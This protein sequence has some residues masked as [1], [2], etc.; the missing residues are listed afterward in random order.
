MS[1]LSLV[2]KISGETL[3]VDLTECLTQEE[4]IHPVLKHQALVYAAWV[5]NET[6][7]T[8]TA[9]GTVAYWEAQ[10]KS[11]TCTTHWQTFTDDE[12][13]RRDAET[14]AICKRCVHYAQVVGGDLYV[15]GLK[16][17]RVSGGFLDRFSLTSHEKVESQD[18]PEVDYPNLEAGNRTK[19]FD[20]HEDQLRSLHV[21]PSLGRSLVR[22]IPIPCKERRLARRYQM[23]GANEK[24]VVTGSYYGNTGRNSKAH[25]HIFNAVSEEV[26]WSFKEDYEHLRNR[27]ARDVAYEKSAW[28]CED[29]VVVWVGEMLHIW[30]IP[31]QSYLSAVNLTGILDAEML[32][33]TEIGG[34]G[35]PI[36]HIELCD[37]EL[38]VTFQ[39]RTHGPSTTIEIVGGQVSHPSVVREAVKIAVFSVNHPEDTQAVA[40]ALHG[41]PRRIA[42]SRWKQIAKVIKAIISCLLEGLRCLGS[43]LSWPIRVLYPRVTLLCTRRNAVLLE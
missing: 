31:T 19:S 29:F 17:G 8:V 10:K 24:W 14:G 28:L 32:G 41:P 36:I 7:L 23:I 15:S 21:N 2:N 22:Q 18:Y 35:N 26:V 12:L 43:I 40:R 20:I 25:F 39:P 30:Y 9:V 38:Q 11:V 42:N 1:Y 37:R 3:K 33:N 4:S 5:A 6:F 13:A 34:E 16:K 27:F